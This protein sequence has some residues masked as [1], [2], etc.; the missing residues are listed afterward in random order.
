ME[1]SS[2]SG[3]DYP[4]INNA[5]KLMKKQGEKYCTAVEKLIEHH[6]L[7]SEPIRRDGSWGAVAE[8]IEATGRFKDSPSGVVNEICELLVIYNG[9]NAT[10]C[11]LPTNEEYGLLKGR[12]APFWNQHNAHTRT[13]EEMVMKDTK[14]GNELLVSQRLRRDEFDTFVEVCRLLGISWRNV[15]DSTGKGVFLDPRYLPFFEMPLPSD[16]HGA[17]FAEQA[18]HPKLH[19]IAKR[20]YEVLLT[21]AT[22]RNRRQKMA[23]K[24]T[25]LSDNNHTPIKKGL[26]LPTTP[27]FWCQIEC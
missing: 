7:S 15:F 1:L 16:P 3:G 8:F 22:Y 13:R 27:R 24:Q 23:E 20:L 25:T 6:G 2:G 10:G 12:L 11:G 18:N 21:Y 14:D 9:F 19:G 17:L 5:T 26:D 4:D